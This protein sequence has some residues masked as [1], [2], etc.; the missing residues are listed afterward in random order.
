MFH[1]VFFYMYLFREHVI[2]QFRHVLNYKMQLNGAVT[3]SS[4]QLL[5]MNV[6]NVIYS[7]HRSHKNYRPGDNGNRQYTLHFIGYTELK[8]MQSNIIVL[9]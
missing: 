3:L 7:F 6:M 2:I 4:G 9:R 5:F 1:K 8:R